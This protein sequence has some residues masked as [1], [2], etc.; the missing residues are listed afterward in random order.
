MMDGIIGVS[1]KMILANCAQK[2]LKLFT[3]VDFNKNEYVLI[4][5]PRYFSSTE[6]R[7][8]EMHES[9]FLILAPEKK[10]QKK[11]HFYYSRIYQNK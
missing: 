7:Q 9:I 8:Q 5:L 2:A 10:E 6:T 11:Y 3:V 1:T 4:P